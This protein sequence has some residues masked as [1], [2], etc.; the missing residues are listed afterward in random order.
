MTI[1]KRALVVSLACVTALWATNVAA[2]KVKMAI[3]SF[4]T[5]AGAPAFGIPG[6]NGAELMIRGINNGELP[7]PYNTKGLAGRQ[8]EAVFYDEAGGGTKQVTELRN[9][10]Q[11]ENVDLVVGYISS[12]T[13]AA[14]VTTT[15]P[16]DRGA[17]DA[18]RSIAAVIG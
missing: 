11:K 14:I 3:P 2:Q 8:I 1:A 10:V 15:S 16:H 6:K 5:G 7:P 18:I 12:G 13:C 4:L 17:E 9:K